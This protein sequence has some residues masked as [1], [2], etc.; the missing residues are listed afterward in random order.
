MSLSLECPGLKSLLTGYNRLVLLPRRAARR[1]PG[2]TLR[3]ADCQRPRDGKIRPLLRDPYPAD[4]GRGTAIAPFYPLVAPGAYFVARTADARWEAQVGVYT[5]GTGEDERSNFDFESS[6]DNGAFFIGELRTR[7]RPLGWPGTHTA[8]V[9][10]TT[11]E[12]DDFESG[13]AVNSGGGPFA[14]IDQLL[15][16]QTPAHPGLGIFVRSYGCRRRTGASSTG[17][18]ASG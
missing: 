1:G 17:T 3:H 6:F 12:L 16:E 5:A 2:G 9:I 4:L 8:R 14:S 18:W 10:G 11:A 13:G 7:R 15:V